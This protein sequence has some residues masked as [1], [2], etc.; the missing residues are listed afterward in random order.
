[1][2][3]FCLKYPSNF[4]NASVKTISAGELLRLQY[5]QDLLRA[6]GYRFNS[7]IVSIYNS[8]NLYS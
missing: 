4:A 1:M 2:K 3:C 6:G 5:H 8:H 7:L